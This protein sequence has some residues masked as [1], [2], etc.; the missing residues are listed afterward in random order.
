MQKIE[1]TPTSRLS[2]EGDDQGG[3]I[4]KLDMTF[5][6]GESMNFGMV[7]QA[8]PELTVNQLQIRVFRRALTMI[9]GMVDEL[10]R[11]EPAAP[12]AAR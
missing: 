10:E 2:I 9:Q 8:S 6:N 12:P 3:L 1:K 7:L 5:S 4:T 11:L